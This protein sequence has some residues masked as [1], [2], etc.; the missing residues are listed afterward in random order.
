MPKQYV[1]LK[2]KRVAVSEITSK[3]KPFPFS[4][5]FHNES[6]SELW[7]DISHHERDINAFEKMIDLNQ[8]DTPFGEGVRDYAS[9]NIKKM[10][11]SIS[12]KKKEILHRHDMC[13]KHKLRFGADKS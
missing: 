2:G 9:I 7:N 8:H 4:N 11:V 12:E 3:E 6:T 13:D 10:N 5:N 1:T